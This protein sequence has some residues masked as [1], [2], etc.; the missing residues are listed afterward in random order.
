MTLCRC[1]LL[2]KS[3]LTRF[4]DDPSLPEES[5]A[6]CR[7]TLDFD[8]PRRAVRTL[9]QTATT[10]ARRQGFVGLSTLSIHPTIAVFDCRGT[11]SLPGKPIAEPEKSAD[12][13]ARR[14]HDETKRAVEF[15]RDC[16]ARNSLDN[17]GMTLISSIHLADKHVNAFWDGTQMTYG[18]ADGQLM[19]DFTLG[20][21][22]IAH[23]LAHGIT[24]HTAGF[25]YIY[26]EPG[27][28]NESMSDVFAIQYR[29]WVEGRDASTDDWTIGAAILGPAAKARG[30]TTMRDLADPGGSHCANPQP[31]RMQEF[32][33]GGDPHSNSGIPNKAFYLAAR[34]LGGRIWERAG[35]IWYAALLDDAAKVDSTFK[36]FAK[37]T[38]K[39]ARNLFGEDS[40]EAKGV[41][42]AWKAVGVLK[43]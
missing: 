29:H 8:T 34:T 30:Y 21:D 3:L 6:A 41:I 5:R 10:A 17:A 7:R 16:F 11:A 36:E 39:H 35:K 13:T 28:L 31:D 33:P 14:A 4:A 12:P 20:S 40:A 25:E 27:A 2:S 38:R 32:M 15:L 26:G 43:R 23:E 18:D 24:Q 42:E 37:L 22:V 1:F 9:Q 19:L